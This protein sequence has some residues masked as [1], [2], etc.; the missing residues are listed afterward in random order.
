MLK[1]KNNIAIIGFWATG[2]TAVGKKLAKILKK[3]FVDTDE[4]VVKKAKM[5]VSE[6]FD[7][8]GEIGF[9]ELE[10]PIVKRVSKMS[11]VVI[12]CGGGVVLNKINMDYLKQNAVTV[13]LTTE[14][15][16]ILS[17]IKKNEDLRILKSN[18]NHLERIKKFLWFRKPFFERFPDII[19]DTS[20]ISIEEV[21]EKVLKKL[22][23]YP[24][25]QIK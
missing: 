14:P 18:E 12:A 5:S 24:E 23:K 1:L 7:K 6:I 16:V 10:I 20:N 8:Y 2:K 25:F 11:N 21:V 4:L 17:R 22:K 13:Y 15:E 3:R 19:V 9:R